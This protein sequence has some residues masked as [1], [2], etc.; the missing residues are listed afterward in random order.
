M[1][2]DERITTLVKLARKEE[3]SSPQKAAKNYL[4]AADML[5]KHS[6][7]H[8]ERESEY[9]DLANKLY[10]RAKKLK[11]EGETDNPDFLS[12]TDNKITFRDIGGLDELKKEIRFKI[13]EPFKKPDLFKFYGKEMGGG[14]LMY[15]PPGCGK[16][17]IAKAT[18][19]E[20]EANFIHV[21]GSDLKSKFVGET[22]KN[23]AELFEQ[24]REAQP[25][26]IFFDEFEAVGGDRTEGQAHERSAVAQ[27]LTEMDGMDSKDQ[28]ILLL[29]A[30]NEPWAIDPALRR[31]GRFGSTIFVPQPDLKARKAILKIHL[32]K[33]PTKEIDYSGLAKVT[34]GFSGADL[35]AVC[36]IATDIPLRES[37]VTGKKRKIAMKDMSAATKRTKSVMKQWFAKARDLLEKKNLTDSFKELVGNKGFAAGEVAVVDTVG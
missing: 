6:Y 12:H 8:P 31:E 27:L 20:A 14:I 10:F 5:L 36:E 1:C 13:I 4:L 21:K 18:A 17:L 7:E 29:A 30:T 3:T 35:K 19:N 33:R 23:I 26:I 25:T 16:S 11:K 15:G 37:L 32:K 24:A 28:Q 22:E 2:N 9:I 34:A